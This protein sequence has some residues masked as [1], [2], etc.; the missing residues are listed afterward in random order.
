M[1]RQEWKKVRVG[2]VQRTDKTQYAPWVS[3]ALEVLQSN[4][5][6]SLPLV[7][8]SRTL[9]QSNRHSGLC[10]GLYWMD[11]P[12]VQTADVFCFSSINGFHVDIVESK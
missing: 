4:C 6:E 10:G 1:T 12:K 8:L 5:W 7:A 9:S 3:D 2:D 11:A